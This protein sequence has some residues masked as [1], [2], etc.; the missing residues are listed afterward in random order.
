MRR[1]SLLAV[2][3][4]G[5]I[6]CS[7]AAPPAAV[8]DA[9][10]YV[11]RLALVDAYAIAHGMAATYAHSRRA[12]PEVVVQLARLDMRAAEALRSLA[13]APPRLGQEQATAAAIAA[14]TEYAARQDLGPVASD[15]P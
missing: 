3:S 6:A 13:D 11:P 7:A 5:L 15:T 1:L 14:L 12:D 9:D 2:A 8:P 10:A 4:L